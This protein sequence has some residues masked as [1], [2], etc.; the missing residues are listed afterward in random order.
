[1]D[2]IDGFLELMLQMWST[3]SRDQEL[4][5]YVHVDRLGFHVDLDAPCGFMQIEEFIEGKIVDVLF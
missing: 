1:M 3:E 5:A 4:H 2:L